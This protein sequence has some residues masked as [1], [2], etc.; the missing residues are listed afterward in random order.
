MGERQ[1]STE[2]NNYNFWVR[3]GLAPDGQGVHRVPEGPGAAAASAR[4]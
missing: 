2:S 1:G 3:F 4:R